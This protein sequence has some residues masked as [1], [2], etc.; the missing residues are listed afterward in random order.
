LSVPAGP[1]YRRQAAAAEARRMTRREGGT[2]QN[3]TCADD[4]AIGAKRATT[5]AA[6]ARDCWTA[7]SLQ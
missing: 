5:I 1:F 6:R 7:G 4:A 2:T 3:Q